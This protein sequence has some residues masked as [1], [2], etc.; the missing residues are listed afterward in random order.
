M[1]AKSSRAG[2]S[3]SRYMFRTHSFTTR[4]PGRN[5]EIELRKIP[6]VS[7]CGI[8]R[9]IREHA[10]HEP[11]GAVLFVSDDGKRINTPRFVPGPGLFPPWPRYTRARK[12]G[13][14]LHNS[15]K[16]RCGPMR[17]P[18]PR[19]LRSVKGGKRAL[20]S[21]PPAGKGRGTRIPATPGS[22][23]LWRAHD[24]RDRTISQERT[25]KVAAGTPLRMKK[26]PRWDYHRQI[27]T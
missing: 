9:C 6:T 18:A 22:S 25:V 23:G 12:A 16:S 26:S 24:K 11:R 4:I 1:G 13:Q 2:V 14:L 17:A 19:P 5:T 20:L 3:R 27:S 10:P 7:G 8:F 21:F 15:R